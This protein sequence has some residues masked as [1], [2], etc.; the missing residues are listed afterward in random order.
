MYVKNTDKVPKDHEL[1]LSNINKAKDSSGFFTWEKKI[2][3]VTKYLALGNYRLVS[4]LTKVDY[5]TI[6]LWKKEPW[7]DDLIEEIKKTRTSELST[8]LSKI[9]DRS[10]EVVADR[11][12]NGDVVMN[13]K[14][15][16]FDRKPVSMRDANIVVKDLLNHQ[17]KMEELSSKIEIQK[18]TVQD[19]LA[20]LAAE[21]AKWNKAITKQTATTI[22]FKE[23]TNAVH[24]ERETGLQEGSGEVYEQAFGDQEESP[25]KSSSERDDEEGAGS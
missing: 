17:L 15:G 9:V 21:F 20:L 13:M 7:W 11:L 25:A 14:T 3:V 22:E 16:E 19:Q 4:E 24:D 23:K 1:K 2:E 5:R 18:E 10:L 8:K 12:E 6:M